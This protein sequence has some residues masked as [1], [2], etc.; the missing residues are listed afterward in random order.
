MSV[1]LV[2][3]FFVLLVSAFADDSPSEAAFNAQNTW[4][5]VQDLW[6]TAVN[7]E[8][9]VLLENALNS[10][11][12]YLTTNSTWT[13]AEF[14]PLTLVGKQAILSYIRNVEAPQY[15]NST[16]FTSS[17]K[18]I[19]AKT[20]GNERVTLSFLV[21]HHQ[22]KEADAQ[23]PLPQVYFEI[24]RVTIVFKS[25]SSTPT[26][27]IESL[28][29]LV[30]K[31]EKDDLIA[32]ILALRAE[33]QRLTAIAN[34][35]ELETQ[36]F[37]THRAVIDE[38]YRNVRYPFA[39]QIIAS[40]ALPSY[41]DPNVKGRIHPVGYFAEA[42]DVIEYFYG[43]SPPP[44][45]TGVVISNSILTKFTN[46][47]NIASS[48]VIFTFSALNGSNAVNLTQKGFWRFDEQDKVLALPKLKM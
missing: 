40:G 39:Q 25:F 11:G 46:D 47:G 20:D 38:L 3:L 6:D 16:R 35:A 34:A 41:F 33:N 37:Q 32:E 12:T 14:T 43:L 29:I 28:S 13:G 36:K 10:L 45:R 7:A 19:Y 1:K 15:V 27:R 2:C 48:E 8:S 21:N 24:E 9:T 17:V 23:N 31:D 42:E 4:L 22:T 26:W 44:G 5:T 30:V 18:S